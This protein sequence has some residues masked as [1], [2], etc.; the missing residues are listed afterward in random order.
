[1]ANGKLAG[2]HMWPASGSK[3]KRMPEERLQLVL[4]MLDSKKKPWFG[5]PSPA[6]N[7]RGVPAELAIRRFDGIKH[8]IWELAL[9]IAYWEYAVFR[10]LTNGPKGGFPRTPSN[11]PA[12]P[13]DPSEADWSADRRLVKQA[14]EAL[15]E[16]VRA[17]D[18]TKLDEQ[19]PNGSIYSYSEILSGVAQHSVYHTGQI[20]LLKRL[21]RGA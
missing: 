12:T 10:M 8:C 11:W 17:F 7:L 4:Q 19:R 5:G 16:A 1:V 2:W 21:E 6:G 9:H 15:I 20:A 14:R 13:E 18:D 3:E